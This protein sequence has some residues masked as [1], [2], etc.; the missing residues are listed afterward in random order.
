MVT[1]F[2]IAAAV[3]VIA[4]AMVIINVNVVHGL[5]C[6]VISML[7]G[8]TLVDA[9]DLGCTDRTVHGSFG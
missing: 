9:L 2:Y 7:A 3:A 4:T 5:L 6:L 1:A 8:A